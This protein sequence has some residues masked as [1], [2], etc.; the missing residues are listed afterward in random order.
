MYLHS[1]KRCTM[2][3]ACY[4]CINRSYQKRRGYTPSPSL[5]ANDW[6]QLTSPLLTKLPAE[7]RCKIYRYLLVSIHD[8]KIVRP[9][10]L[11]KERTSYFASRG[12]F[13]HIHH[14]PD[15]EIDATILRTC[16]RVYFEALSILYT[17]NQFEF[18]D[19]LQ[20]QEFKQE[21]IRENKGEY[22]CPRYSHENKLP[23]R[24]AS[25]VVLSHMIKLLINPFLR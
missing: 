22:T 5:L 21:G 13:I 7:V 15:P 12:S 10:A 8:A 24:T 23:N 19:L 4:H 6:Q 9:V 2:R 14:G 16:R 11:R 25:V 17:K 20:I 1:K 3:Y 18:S